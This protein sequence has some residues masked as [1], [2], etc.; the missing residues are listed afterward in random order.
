MD[1]LSFQRRINPR[2]NCIASRKSMGLF[3]SII[4]IWTAHKRQKSFLCMILK[5]KSLYNYHAQTFSG[6]LLAKTSSYQIH[7]SSSLRTSLWWVCVSNTAISVRWLY[8]I[9]SGDSLIVSYWRKMTT[10]QLASRWTC[11]LIKVLYAMRKLLME[12]K[13]YQATT[14]ISSKMFTSQQNMY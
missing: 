11:N 7:L 3:S 6:E 8:Q 10:K 4:T 5:G 9:S 2:N 1:G 13:K 14:Q 12:K